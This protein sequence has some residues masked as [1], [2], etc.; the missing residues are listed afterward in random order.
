[1]GCDFTVMDR[2]IES[3]R[4]PVPDGKLVYCALG[5]GSSM[6]G[7]P[8]PSLKLVL[9]GDER[10]EIDGRTISVKPGEFL[11]LDAG[12]QCIGT[13]RSA[14]TGLCL[15]LPTNGAANL[16]AGHGDDPVLGRALV[17]STRASAL[18]RTLWDYGRRIAHNPLLGPAIADELVARVEVAIA[19]P[20]ERSRAAIDGLKAVKLSTRRELFRRLE[21]ARE[22]LHA[23]I[24]RAV[25]LAEMASVAG[26]SQFHL[27]RYFKDAYGE[28]PISYHRALRLDRAA[29]L[30]AAGGRSL[31]EVAEA[32]GY[33]DQV[34]LSHAFRR[35]YGVSPQSWTRQR[36]LAA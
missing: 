29:K 11:Y 32:T 13:N 36:G 2:Q 28:S 16:P 24:A 6:I 5:P 18:G 26:L 15:L 31:A 30:L 8:A 7:A 3:P 20:L 34:A 12:S 25:T 17:L 10:Y 23:H 19:E 9:D 21:R 27:A 4:G 14:M 33:S 35:T 1:M 22:F